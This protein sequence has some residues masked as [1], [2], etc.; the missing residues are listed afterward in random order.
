[1]TH[2]VFEDWLKKL[3]H[4]FVSKGRKIILVAVNGNA[5]MKMPEL[6]AIS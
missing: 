6:S 5:P 3:N 2:D 4:Q 1:M